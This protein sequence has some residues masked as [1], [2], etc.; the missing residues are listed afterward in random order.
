METFD[1]LL[2]LFVA[3]LL[4]SWLRTLYDRKMSPWVVRK[5]K[6]RHALP[7]VKR[8]NLLHIAGHLLDRDKGYCFC[9]GN[10]HIIY[11]TGSSP[12]T[13]ILGLYCTSCGKG[14]HKDAQ[15]NT[16]LSDFSETRENNWAVWGNLLTLLPYWERGLAAPTGE[17]KKPEPEGKNAKVLTLVKDEE[18]K[19]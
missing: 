11:G 2:Q 18:K 19:D 1:Y 16:V 5:S 8:L 10:L 13:G 7:L 14:Y 12:F 3:A 4:G 15:K 9:R 17:E 6:A